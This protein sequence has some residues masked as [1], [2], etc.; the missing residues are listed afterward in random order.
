MGDRRE[1]IKTGALAGLATLLI[2]GRAKGASHFP[3]HTTARK[4]GSPPLDKLQER[5]RSELKM[6]TDWLSQNNA[7]GFIGEFGFPCDRT[8]LDEYNCGKTPRNFKDDYRKWNELAESWFQKADAAKLWATIWAT[9]EWW[10]DY[11]LSVYRKS[12][13]NADSVNI[14]NTQSLV[15]E[16]HLSTTDYERGITVAGG[17]FGANSGTEETLND[18]SNKNPGTYDD[19]Y[20]YD[21]QATFDY[22][23]SRGITLVRIPFRW[24][25][26]QPQLNG[27]LD[28]QELKRLKG[29]VTRAR[30]SRSNMPAGIRVILDLHNFGAYYEYSS[31]IGKGRRR[32]FRER[33]F[34]QYLVDLWSRLSAE[35]K[36]I[37]NVYYG[38]MCE[39][40]DS[41][42]ENANGKRTAVTEAWEL[43]SQQI[44]DKI[45]NSGDAK[46]IIVS[47]YLWSGI[48]NW[49]K[50]HPK[51]WIRDRQNSVMYEAHHYWDGDSSGHYCLS[52]DD[53]LR[54]IT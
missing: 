34:A 33:G 30:Q 47:G 26:I 42:T 36:S 52:Y 24:E 2:A 21:S 32:D 46:L 5:A 39:P 15:F 14:P 38:L 49:N 53:E 28:L 45:R 4:I 41:Q 8:K 9:G 22:L 44:V 50:Q 51:G 48:V 6:F 17:E 43:G 7:A 23:A 19:D 40:V 1:F 31:G 35:F 16:K 20:H 25:R 12:S 10:G 13:E 54:K 37:P 3:A 29:A 11:T 27:S 18:F